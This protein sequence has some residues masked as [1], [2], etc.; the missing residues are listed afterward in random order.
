MRI[1][2]RNGEQS[3]GKQ[4][5]LKTSRHRFDLLLGDSSSLTHSP[6]LLAADIINTA[7]S[8][9]ATT[10]TE[11]NVC[12]TAHIERSSALERC[13]PYWWLGR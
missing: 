5:Q 7:N 3:N 4:G 2:R 10:N 13:G 8:D 6:Y 11:A 9:D 12:K 1:T